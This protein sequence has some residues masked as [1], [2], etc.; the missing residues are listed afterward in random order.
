MASTGEQVLQLSYI[1]KVRTFIPQLCQFVAVE[2]PM[3][4]VNV[5]SF[6]LL[7]LS[8]VPEPQEGIDQARQPS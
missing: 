8:R 7:I 6:P 4:S 1:T 5:P 3:G 2:L